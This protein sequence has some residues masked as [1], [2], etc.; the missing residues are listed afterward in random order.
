MDLVERVHR[1][2]FYQHIIKHP[3]HSVWEPAFWLVS[4][5]N[6]HKL[7]AWKRKGFR[8]LFSKSKTVAYLV[9]LIKTT[10]LCSFTTS[11]H[12]SSISASG[13]LV[14]NPF[15]NVKFF[16]DVRVDRSDHSVFPWTLPWGSL[17]SF[18]ARCSSIHFFHSICSSC[19][20][21]CLTGLQQTEEHS[22]GSSNLCSFTLALIFRERP[23][24]CSVSS[25]S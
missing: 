20:V 22:S 15:V 13:K 10:V 19:V 9:P 25:M 24:Y 23:M 4:A 16:F 18:V 8:Y 12:A 6:G 3:A 14:H 17:P 11:R 21:A 5:E 7:F 2:V 1:L